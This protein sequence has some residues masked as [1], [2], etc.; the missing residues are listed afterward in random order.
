[1]SRSMLYTSTH[2]THQKSSRFGS[3]IIEIQLHHTAN[4][5]ASQTINMMTS[6]SRQVSA[7]AVVGPRGQL[8]EV[9]EEE[10]RAWTS[11]SASRDSQAFTMECVNS[12]LGDASGWP[13]S[14]ENVEG[15]ASLAADVAFRNGFTISRS[16]LYG[17][18]EMLGRWGVSYSTACPGGMPLDYIGNEAER[19]RQ[20]LVAG[21]PSPNQ[22]LEEIMSVPVLIQSAQNGALYVYE[23]GVAHV[24]SMARVAS[25]QTMR[26]QLG[27]EVKPV[28]M[29]DAD[30]SAVSELAREA[31]GSYIVRGVINDLSDEKKGGILHRIAAKLGA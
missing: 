8:Y 28:R 22:Q 11:G 15:I 30:I 18:R 21:T 4:G 2:P 20:A 10:S 1:M 24:A 14:P 31:N 27:L 26:A 19:K 23:G 29:N 5:S 25:I 9:V 13:Q 3:R 7:N 17:H 6:G 12:A 16:N